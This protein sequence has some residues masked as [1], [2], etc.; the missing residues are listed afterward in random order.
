MIAEIMRAL[1]EGKITALDLG[2]WSWLSWQSDRAGVYSA[3]RAATADQLRI[4][5]R[6]LRASFERL[7]SVGAI[8]VLTK[9][10]KRRSRWGI[11]PKF[12]KKE[13]KQPKNVIPLQQTN[14]GGDTTEKK[15]AAL[16]GLPF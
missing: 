9:K 14:K 11:R 1:D 16:E 3:A 5:E 6:Q 12:D 7:A 4:T 10:G 8:V 13:K 2:V 15:P